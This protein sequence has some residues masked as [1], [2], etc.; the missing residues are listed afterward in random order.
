MA[1]LIHTYGGTHRALGAFLFVADA[2]LDTRSVVQTIQ[3]LISQSTWYNDGTYVA[4]NG[5]QVYVENT[6]EM[7]LLTNASGLK[8]SLKPNEYFQGELN[9]ATNTRIPPTDAEVQSIVD[10]YW[11]KLA[12]SSSLSSLSG[13][14]H[15]KGRAESVSP[16]LS[17]IV[18]CET[19]ASQGGETAN[20]PVP[21]GTAKDLEEDLYYGWSAENTDF[22][23]DSTTLKSTTTIYD[24]SDSTTTIVGVKWNN[25]TYYLESEAQG[26]A[27]AG[28]IL[29]DINGNKIIVDDIWSYNNNDSIGVYPYNDEGIYSEDDLLGQ[30]KFVKYTAYQFTEKKN[31]YSTTHEYTIIPASPDNSGHVYQIEDNEY[32]SNGTIWVNLGSP[33][34]DWIVID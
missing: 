27:D 13:V 26:V 8:A 15:F 11:T 14:F 21:I 10:L 16:D 31:T 30:G 28:I 2:P 6:N 23:T 25:S 19:A 33:L 24:R 22:W 32:A 7:Y 4:F 17:Y 20:H 12:L 34:E 3:H 5:L 18:V 29:V 9:P 1:N